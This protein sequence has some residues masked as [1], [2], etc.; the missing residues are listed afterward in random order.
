M[1]LVI[2]FPRLLE[3]GIYLCNDVNK[4]YTYCTAKHKETWKVFWIL[5]VLVHKKKDTEK[6]IIPINPTYSLW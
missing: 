2:P 5:G 6:L 3:A 1:S 4:I